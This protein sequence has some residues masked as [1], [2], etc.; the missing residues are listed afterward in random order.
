MGKLSWV[1]VSQKRI[2]SGDNVVSSVLISTKLASQV[3]ERWQW[4]CRF[5]KDDFAAFF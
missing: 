2:L 3:V 4:L 1:A 5:E